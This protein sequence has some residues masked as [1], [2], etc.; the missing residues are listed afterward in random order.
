[1]C[2][3]YCPQAHW[4]CERSRMA[5]PDKFQHGSGWLSVY[6]QSGTLRCSPAVTWKPKLV[7]RSPVL[8]RPCG[9]D[10]CRVVRRSSR[11]V[12]CERPACPDTAYADAGLGSAVTSGTA[13]IR[14]PV[15]TSV[16][17][18]TKPLKTV[19]VPEEHLDRALGRVFPR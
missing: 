5:I 1:M 12:E 7:M 16:T 6:A 17:A 2:P 8:V 9:F 4:L 11:A 14:T 19:R 3:H 15:I 18:C 10:M 13:V